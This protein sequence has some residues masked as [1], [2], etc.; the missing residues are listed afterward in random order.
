MRQRIEGETLPNFGLL[1]D[2]LVHEA[3]AL[4]VVENNNFNAALLEVLF[5]AE[6]GL[7]LAN[8]DA[9]DAVQETCSSAWMGQS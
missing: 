8:D 9:G 5:A 1:G 7:V 2:E 3:L 4:G 6:E